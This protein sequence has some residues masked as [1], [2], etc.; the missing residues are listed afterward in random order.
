[1]AGQ[2]KELSPCYYRTYW[3]LLVRLTKFG[4]LSCEMSM[5]QTELNRSKNW[6]EEDHLDLPLVRGSQG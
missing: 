4:G 3:H 1:M 2:R 6:R 5:K